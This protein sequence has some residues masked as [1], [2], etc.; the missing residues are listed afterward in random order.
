M[1]EKGDII[2]IPAG[3]AHKCSKTSADFFCVGAYPGG[4]EYDI[5]LGAKKE[6]EKAK[7]RLAKVSKPGLDPVFGKQG[8]LKSFWK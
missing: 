7:P 3:V 5:N 4:S 2:I 1:I 6:L 8:F